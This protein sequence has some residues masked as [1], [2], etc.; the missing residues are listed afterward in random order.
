[1]RALGGLAGFAAAAA[2]ALAVV[3]GSFG[4]GHHAEAGYDDLYVKSEAG[5][6]FELLMHWYDYVHEKWVWGYVC[7][8]GSEPLPDDGIPAR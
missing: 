1:M 4:G 2:V 3:S 5:E 7:P 6:C 8:D